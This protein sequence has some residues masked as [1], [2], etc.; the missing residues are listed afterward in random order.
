M[1]WRYARTAPMP[2]TPSIRKA[3][4]ILGHNLVFRDAD[5]NDAEF[6]LGLR[7]D[8]RK[9]RFISPTSPRLAQQIEWLTA[10]KDTRDQA[11]FIVEDA[12]GEKAGTIRLYDPAGDCFCWGSWIMK[13]GAPLNYAVESVLVLYRYALHD[14]GFA[15]SCFAVRKDNRSVW[16]FM[17][18]FGA[19]RTGETGIDFLYETARDRIEASLV[20]YSR[21]LPHPIKVLND[22]VS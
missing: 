8:P 13:A 9:K 1:N 4:R 17:E 7:T 5:V 10:Y 2:D 22:P 19:Q 21:F 16:H 11:Y 18:R 20:S 3:S 15:R 14:L 12:R 6:I